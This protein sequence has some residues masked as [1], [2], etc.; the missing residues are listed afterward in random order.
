MIQSQSTLTEVPDPPFPSRILRSIGRLVPDLPYVRG[1][2]NRI[3]KPLNNILGYTGPYNCD[4]LGFKMVL[5]PSECVDGNLYFA[6]HL[7]DRREISFLI[8][9]FPRDGVLIDGG[10]YKGFWS[11]RFATRFPD[12]RV[13]AIEANPSIFESLSRN[14]A[15]NSLRN[16]TAFNV[17]LSDAEGEAELFLNISGNL[18]G[19]SFIRN[20]RVETSSVR[21]KTAPLA[22]VVSAAGLQK[23]DILKPA[24]E[25]MELRVLTSFFQDVSDVLYPSYICCE[26]WGDSGV[27]ELLRAKGYCEVARGRE[28]VVFERR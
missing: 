4:V 18:G 16:V 25:G 9:R 17:G 11:L 24:L 12:A 3:L 21:V 15:K 2:S 10:L 7:Y 14:I 22:S 28:N 23:I 1:A 27:S 19:S 13:I 20:D 5:S 6:P 8:Q 26:T